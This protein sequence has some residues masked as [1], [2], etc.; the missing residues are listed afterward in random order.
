MLPQSTLLP[1]GKHG[2]NHTSSLAFLKGSMTYIAKANTE[3]GIYS[4]QLTQY[5]VSSPEGCLKTYLYEDGQNHDIL[6]K[7]KGFGAV[8]LMK[9]QS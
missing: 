7:Q 6:L 2:N 5:L 9:T 1:R 8:N 4:C 3:S